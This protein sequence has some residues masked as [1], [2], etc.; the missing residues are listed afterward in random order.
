[1]S[2]RAASAKSPLAS[3]R[4]RSDLSFQR[5]PTAVRR[6]FS[7]ALPATRCSRHVLAASGRFYK[8]RSNEVDIWTIATNG[9]VPHESR[10]G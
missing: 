3:M 8:L 6:Y 1:M 7:E 10:G 4:C 2:L 9:S 5:S